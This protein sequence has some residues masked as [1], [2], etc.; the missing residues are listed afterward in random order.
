M[1][2]LQA[3][4][5]PHSRDAEEAALGSFII[6][7]ERLKSVDLRG[8]DFYI[9]RNR[10]IF[11]AMRRL[12]EKRTPIDLITLTEEIGENLEEIGGPAYLIALVNSTALSYNA[13]Y[14]AEIIKDK[15]SRR[16]D[17]ETANLIASGAYNGGVDRASA[18]SQLTKNENIKG[19]AKKLGD[20]LSKFYDMVGERAKNPRD[21]W[22][23]STGFPDLDKMLGGL[24]KQQT[25]MLVGAPGVGKTTLL[26]QIIL[27]AAKKGR[28][29]ALYEMEMDKNPRLIARLIQML[30]GVPVRNM[31]SGR[32][33]DSDWPKFTHGIELLE[34]L[35]IYISD[36]PVMSTMQIRA[37]IARLKSKHSIDILGLDYM[38]LLS[39]SDGG[40][41]NS[42]TTNK[43]RRFRTICREFDLSGLTVQSVTKE[44][45]K[46]IVP[47]LADMSGPASVSFDA[48]NV[49]FLVENPDA[50]QGNN[51]IYKLLPAKGR[52]NDTGFSS[53]SLVK[54]I[55]QLEFNSA[56]TRKVSFDEKE[57]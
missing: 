25:M 35:P 4:Q 39:D 7:P 42:D 11:D 14:Y 5:I 32:M 34:S 33:E 21:I 50:N 54:R 57:K 16:R 1:K 22:G 28:G 31:M 48:D 18:I 44:G 56:T 2:N 3:P 36:N 13:E 41:S 46:G 27:N 38:N 6:D 15:S 26:L 20:D 19:G 23:I 45:M 10:W 30:T 53:I 43:A 9:I 51:K 37:D 40:D 29:A 12:D 17:L 24:Q 8:T 49:F 52:D 47:K 55:G